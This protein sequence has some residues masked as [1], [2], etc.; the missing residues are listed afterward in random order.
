MDGLVVVR[1]RMTNLDMM[2][3]VRVRVSFEGETRECRN[4]TCSEFRSKRH[5]ELD[6]DLWKARL[7]AWDR[8]SDAVWNYDLNNI[9]I[10]WK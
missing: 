2:L 5:E 8:R 9:V 4:E 1:M 6:I 3:R 10:G 7:L